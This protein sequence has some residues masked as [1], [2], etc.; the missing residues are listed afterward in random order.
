MS[1]KINTKKFL[2]NI[3][4]N[5]ILERLFKSVDCE[6]VPFIAENTAQKDREK[7]LMAY[8]KS[9]EADVRVQLLE[10]INLISVVANKNGARIIKEYLDSNKYEPLD[11]IAE[12]V[13]EK[14]VAFYFE[15]EEKFEDVYLLCN[16]MS[17][18]G[19][20]RFESGSKEVFS[21]EEK[22]TEFQGAIMEHIAKSNDSRFGSV[23]TVKSDKNYYTQ[24][25][26]E[27]APELDSKIDPVSNKATA[28]TKRKLKE[29]YF[30]YLPENKTLLTK[31]IG[32][33]EEQYFFAEA[34]SRIYV[35]FNL[36]PKEYLYDLSKFVGNED[37]NQPL[38]G[39]A[40]IVSWKILS[41]SLERSV[42]KEVVSVSCNP[43]I[44]G[45]G[46][47]AF[48][49]LA[50]TF[51]LKEIGFEFTKVKLQM[52]VRDENSKKGESK[53][54]VGL[55]KN[56]STLNLLRK[57]HLIADKILAACEVG[58]GYKEVEMKHKSEE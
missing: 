53:V 38:V 19:F 2:S 24:F 1:K 21:L 25:V 47:Q 27:D 14:A 7:T 58:I 42:T 12:S 32:N 41:V 40:D 11:V 44:E 29:M 20:K 49:S 30:V 55:S 51:N 23:K 31:T 43:K 9:L 13:T 39:S 48:H 26:F 33:F 17:K 36:S 57:E 28:T 16:I 46:M 8:Y 15:H 56:K 52:I 3:T 22:D 5:A 35:D 18:S 50:E 45:E 6:D 4:E 37:H 54:V 10:K 34:Y